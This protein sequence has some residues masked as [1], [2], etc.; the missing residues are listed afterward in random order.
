MIK[1]YEILTDQERMQALLIFVLMLGVAI[2]EAMGVA[3]IMPF[4]AVL[5]D[6]SIIEKNSLLNSLY[7]YF[8][9][10]SKDSFLYI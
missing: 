7:K 1:L 6:P 9:F 2:L 3:S 4:L 5:V 8:S 10:E